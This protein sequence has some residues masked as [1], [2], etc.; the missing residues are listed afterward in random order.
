MST[1]KDLI[2]QAEEAA[3]ALVEAKRK[4]WSAFL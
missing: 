1:L 4:V 3:N 2:K